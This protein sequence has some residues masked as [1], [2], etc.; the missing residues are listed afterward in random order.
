LEQCKID[1]FLKGRTS[2]FLVKVYDC[3]VT[4]YGHLNGII[5]V[6]WI[7]NI[8][9]V[10]PDRKVHSLPEVVNKWQPSGKPES[11][12]RTSVARISTFIFVYMILGNLGKIC[13]IFFM[14]LAS[15]L[16][17]LHLW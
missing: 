16:F 14:L 13:W 10:K 6:W 2:G 7:G 11:E 9:K 3:T 1:Q 8:I 15:L 17:A 12:T 4:D 5:D